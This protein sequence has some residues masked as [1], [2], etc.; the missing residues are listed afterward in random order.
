MN[1]SRKE[2]SEDKINEARKTI[3]ACNEEN[4]SDLPSNLKKMTNGFFIKRL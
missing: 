4:K 1:P 2:G 3:D